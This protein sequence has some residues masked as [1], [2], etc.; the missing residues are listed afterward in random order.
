M[1]EIIKSLYKKR[2]YIK[3]IIIRDDTDIQ[4]EVSNGKML[5]GREFNVQNIDEIDLKEVLSTIND[6]FAERILKDK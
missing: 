2:S 3:I 5:G 1:E 4:V 6:S